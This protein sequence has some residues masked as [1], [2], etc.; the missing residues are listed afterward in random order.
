MNIV[1][2]AA[3]LARPLIGQHDK[4]ARLTGELLAKNRDHLAWLS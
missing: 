4:A 1:V 2:Y 3:L